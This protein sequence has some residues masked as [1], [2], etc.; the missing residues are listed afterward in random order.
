MDA[1]TIGIN[2]KTRSCSNRA[3]SVWRRSAGGS[4]FSPSWLASREVDDLGNRARAT[5]D[6][7][8]DLHHLPWLT[9]IA[10]SICKDLLSPIDQKTVYAEHSIE[11]VLRADQRRPRRLPVD[12]GEQRDYDAR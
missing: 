6:R 9:R 5:D 2:P 4:A 10:Q 11:G 12:H 3:L 8:P 7:L 1:K